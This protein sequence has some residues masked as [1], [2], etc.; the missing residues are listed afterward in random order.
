MEDGLGNP[1]F[2]GSPS[3]CRDSKTETYGEGLIMFSQSHRNSTD[4]SQRRH[5]TEVKYKE[6]KMKS[7]I[8]EIGSLV[9]EQSLVPHP[10]SIQIK[11]LNDFCP[12]IAGTTLNVFT[13]T[14]CENQSF[15]KCDGK[16]MTQD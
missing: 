15:C 10:L 5:Q 16:S 9:S 7:L 3:Q 14:L 11:G 6:S 13:V 2:F 4:Q 1:L 8:L 12:S